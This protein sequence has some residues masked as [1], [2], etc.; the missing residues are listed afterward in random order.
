MDIFTEF[1][2][3]IAFS[4]GIIVLFGLLIA[5]CRTFAC[6]IAGQAGTKMLLFTGIIGTPI[7][8][9]SHALFCIVFG[10]RITEIKL[11]DPDGE[12][13]TLGYVSHS[14]NPQN[15]YHQIG[16][17]FIGIAP[18]LGG[19]GAIILLMYLLTPTVFADVY[20]DL[21]YLSGSTFNVFDGSTYGILRETV[22]GVI[23]SIFDPKNAGNALWWLFIVLS[24][25]IA[26]H[27]ELSFADVKGG[28]KG[29][30]F[31]ALIWLAADAVSYFVSAPLLSDFTG[32]VISFSATITAFL[33]VSLVFSLLLVLLSFVVKA[34]LGLKR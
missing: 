11:Y 15:V 33:I 21:S 23:G 34:F 32:T 2:S 16:N 5:L 20:S 6:R 1:L 27:M 12:N 9:L 10:H 14:Y 29:F 13:G 3:Q 28:F 25:T 7:H 24:L 4:V 19:S 18:S 8:E 26:S 22:T 17:F 31:V 30:V